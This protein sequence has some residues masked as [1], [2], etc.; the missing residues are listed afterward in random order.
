MGRIKATRFARGCLLVKGRVDDGRDNPSLLMMECIFY[1]RFTRVA[2]NEEMTVSIKKIISYLRPHDWA[3][4][5]YIAITGFIIISGAGK[6]RNVAPHL[7]TRCVFIGIIASLVFLDSKFHHWTIRLVRN[8]YPLV[9][10]S[11]FYAETA[12]LNHLLFD[13]D[14]DPWIAKIEQAIFGCQPSIEFGKRVPWRWFIDLMSFGYVS[15][16]L[17]IFGVCLWIYKFAPEK[18]SETIFV[19]LSSFFLCYLF[20]IVVPVA[21]PQFYFPAPDSQVPKGY[22][23][24]NILELVRAAGERPTAAFP[25][26]HVA[27]TCLLLFLS[28]KNARKILWWII[29]SALLLF[30]STV[31]IKAHYVVD[32]VAGML[33]FPVLYWIGSHFYR[34]VERFDSDFNHD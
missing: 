22:F 32:V 13:H 19:I 11:Y 24:R 9:L 23:F 31:Y 4:L 10:L 3:T 30:L 14:F 20:F 5:V 6:L 18:F 17:M 21:G 16:F 2:L 25:S 26:S 8:F 7:L 33:T 29:P 27:I 34:K 15:Y 28:A 1:L 12:Y